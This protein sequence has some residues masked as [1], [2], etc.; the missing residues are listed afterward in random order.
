MKFYGRG[1][2]VV[3]LEDSGMALKM[4]SPVYISFPTAMQLLTF[5]RMLE[6]R[7]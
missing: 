5:R 6:L 4:P 1:V 7:F 2:I 3:I